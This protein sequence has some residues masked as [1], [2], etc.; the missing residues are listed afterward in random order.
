MG[1]PL[2]DDDIVGALF[3]P[4]LNLSI[5]KLTMHRIW[6]IYYQHITFFTKP[7][8][9]KTAHEK[10]KYLIE[11]ATNKSKSSSPL[12]NLDHLIL[13]IDFLD[14]MQT[15]LSYLLKYR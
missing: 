15:I 5:S 7:F 12:F 8:K 14:F 4:K 13:M 11:R 2:E 10:N 3:C 6:Y 9:L 1:T